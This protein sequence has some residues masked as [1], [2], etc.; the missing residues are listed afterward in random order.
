M[1]AGED[2]NQDLGWVNRE[3]IVAADPG[4]GRGGSRHNMADQCFLGIPAVKKPMYQM[5]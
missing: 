2:G 4:L 5:F 1:E 3:Y